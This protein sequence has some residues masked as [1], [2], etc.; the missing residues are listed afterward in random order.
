MR[1]GHR[2]AP[3]PCT[4]HLEALGHGGWDAKL[5]PTAQ[6]SL[7][8][9]AWAWTLG[10]SA[11]VPCLPHPLTCPSLP[12]VPLT[13]QLVP[14]HLG[15]SLQFVYVFPALSPSL[16][17]LRFFY[18]LPSFCCVQ[19]VPEAHPP[20]QCLPLGASEGPG[21]GPVQAEVGGKVG[22]ERGCGPRGSR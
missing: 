16:H 6:A 5:G 20:L 4:C 12:P 8:L 13:L 11:C 14:L 19:R 21:R 2:E 17:T 18:L 3:E 7:E 1:Q 22:G 15:I 10:H 9:Q